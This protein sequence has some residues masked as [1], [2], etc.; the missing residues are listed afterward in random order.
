[1]SVVESPEGVVAR[2]ATF[3]ILQHVR[4]GTPFDRALEKGFEGLNDL[5]R[6]FAHEVAAGVLRHRDAID[7]VLGP[8]AQNGWHTVPEPLK[9]VLRLGAYQITYLDRVPL[10][11]AVSTSVDLARSVAGPKQAG[12]VNAVLRKVAS[13]GRV[14]T[15]TDRVDAAGLAEEFSHPAWLVTQWLNRFG[16]Q[17]VRALLQW[18][19][20]RPAIVLQPGRETLSTIQH[21]LQEEGIGTTPVEHGMG[22]I[23]QG[24]RPASLP[25][26]EEGAFVVQDPAQAWV[27]RYAAPPVGSQ[28]L[29]ACAAPG[30]KTLALARE[31][32]L[33]VATDKR[34]SR[35]SRLQQNLRR[36]GRD[37]VSVVVA[38]AQAPPVT[39]M[40]LVLVDAPCSGTGTF[41]RHPDARHRL[42]PDEF[43]RLVEIQTK[44]LEGASAVVRTG[45]L[46]VYATCSL[47]PEENED[48]VE[49]FLTGHPAFRREPP[50]GIPPEMLTPVGDLAL[51]PQRHRMD[52][53]YACRLRR[54]E[55]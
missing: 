18:N 24:G 35:V 3:A 11:A 51:L 12:F 42:R 17:E 41:A 40:D 43:G 23:I 6:R 26:Y 8:L 49:H 50:S 33:V 54:V 13:R 30:G 28:V 36:A 9:D 7:R 31:A 20:S 38:D 25:G 34:Q 48:Q 27:V 37:V 53:A 14:E 19:N 10:H 46:L 21:R 29:D 45:G 5:D 32:G 22:L 44:I 15:A 2:R 52:G 39:E 4:Q 1:M 55:A 47:E 16:Q